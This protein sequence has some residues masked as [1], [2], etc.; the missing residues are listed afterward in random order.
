VW[1]GS[2]SAVEAQQSAPVVPPIRGQ[3]RSLDGAPLADA[4]V[5]ADDASESVRSDARGLFS[6]PNLSKGI[7]TISVRRLGYLPAAASVTVPQKGDSLAVVMV[8]ARANLDT[9]KVTARVNVLAGIVVDERN[10]PLAGASVELNYGPG[11]SVVTGADGWFSF[12]AERT[13]PTVI[14]VAH[15]GYVGTMQSVRLEDSRGIVVHMTQI[16][17]TLSKNRQAILSGLGNTARHVWLETQERLVRRSLRSVV[18]TRDELALYDDLPLGEAIMRAQSA[19]NIMQ[20]LMAS[21]N[22]ACV[23]LNGNQA[24][25]PVSLDTYS[26]EDIE[27]VE[28]YPPEAGP[29]RTVAAYMQNAGCRRVATDALSR[30]VF[31]AV[32]W[33]RN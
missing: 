3:V 16:D 32:V 13:G 9:V 11:G 15:T 30:G 28:L 17:T 5:K 7:H 12:V 31:Y 22:S 24:V 10:R 6:I 4:E 27:F 25:G 14:H 2:I 21:N 29:P 8:P 18:V 33:V 20:D 1:L 26:T 19:A 23:L